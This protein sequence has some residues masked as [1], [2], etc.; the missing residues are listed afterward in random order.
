MALDLLRALRSGPIAE[1]I[2]FETRAA[3]GAHPLLD[4]AAER[5]LARV[6]GGVDEIDARRFA[7]DLALVTQAS[8]LAQTAPGSVLAAFCDS[9]LDGAPDAFGQLGGSTDFDSILR[10]AAPH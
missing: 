9:R 5:L 6:E 8:L 4:R 1:A 3:K 7:R 10:R 2:A